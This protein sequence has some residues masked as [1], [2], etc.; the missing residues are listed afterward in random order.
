MQMIWRFI[1]VAYMV[2]VMVI[3][4]VEQFVTNVLENCYKVISLK[5][6]KTGF[7]S[8]ESKV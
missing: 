2:T 4:H 1:Y 7:S 5:I 6:M 3:G 8:N